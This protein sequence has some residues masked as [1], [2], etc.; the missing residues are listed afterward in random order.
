M[1]PEKHVQNACI[2]LL[3]SK[4]YIVLRYGVNGWPDVIALH[5]SGRNTGW[6]GGREDRLAA[7][8]CNWRNTAPLNT[9]VIKYGVNFYNPM[10]HTKLFLE[11]KEPCGGILNPRQRI[12]LDRLHAA[13]ISAVI[14]S[15]SQLQSLLSSIA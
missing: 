10:K 6:K 11:F 13:G 3:R 7:A 2:K 12:I 14:T 4:G 15:E 9:R 8:Y 5:P 1:G